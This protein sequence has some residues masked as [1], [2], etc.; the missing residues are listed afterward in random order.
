MKGVKRPPTP[1]SVFAKSDTTEGMAYTGAGFPFGGMLGKVTEN[2]GNPS[3]TI[4]RRSDSRLCDETI[5]G[6]STCFRSTAHSSRAIAAARSSRRRPASS[7]AWRWPRS[8]LSTRSGLS[9]PPTKLRRTLA[10]EVGA[11]DLTL[12]TLARQ[13]RHLV[14]KA[15]IVD[16]KGAVQNVMVHVGPGIR[17]LDQPQRRW[18]MASS[19]QYDGCRAAS[20]TPKSAMASGDVQVAL[21]GEGRRRAQDPDPDGTPRYPWETRLLQAREIEL[22]EKPGRVAVSSQLLKML[23]TVQ[24]KS[25]SMLGPLID[26]EKDCKLTKDRR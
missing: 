18:I 23:K 16:P 3:V 4:T 10:G 15:E 19:A 5:T 25:F 13:E 24:R 9:F 7:S 2:K 21:S 8:G 17:R 12:K 26:P 6:K 20:A 11:L 1:L 14:I 22:P